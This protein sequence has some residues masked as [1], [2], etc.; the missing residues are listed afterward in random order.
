MT[1][2][3]VNSQVSPYKVRSDVKS[4]SPLGGKVLLRVALFSM[5]PVCLCAFALSGDCPPLCSLLVARCS[6][7][8]A[9]AAAAAAGSRSWGAALHSDGPAWAVPLLRD[10]TRTHAA[11][12]RT[13][14]RIRSQSAPIW[15]DLNHAGHFW[16]KMTS[17]Q[18][19]VVN[20]GSIKSPLSN[21]YLKKLHYI[22]WWHVTEY[23][24]SNCTRLRYF[25]LVFPFSAT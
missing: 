22:Q 2:R 7:T 1:K 3:A 18:S 10:N 5:I 21:V 15:S 11:C 16:D 17:Q 19:S 24:Y 25:T 6:L 13:H 4:R 14:A 12:T 8:A 9:V 20:M 23:I